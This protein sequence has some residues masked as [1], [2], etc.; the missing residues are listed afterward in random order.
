M[1]QGFQNSWSSSKDETENHE[2][3]NEGDE[4]GVDTPDMT[5]IRYEL[6]NLLFFLYLYD[7]F[8]MFRKI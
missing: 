7:Y 1:N 8:T 5:T 2:A 4:A 6:K 3:V